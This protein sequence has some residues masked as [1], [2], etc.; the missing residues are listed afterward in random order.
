MPKRREKGVVV[1]K[2]SD[3]TGLVSRVLVASYDEIE[4]R[5]E[6]ARQCL[7]A[8]VGKGGASVVAKVILPF[9]LHRLEKMQKELRIMRLD[10]RRRLAT[11]HWMEK[12]EALRNLRGD[13]NG[14][15]RS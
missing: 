9:Q 13:S 7:A 12:K 4:A 5:L 15:K 11:L 14:N 6:F 1:G 3:T 2:G 10:L 8:L